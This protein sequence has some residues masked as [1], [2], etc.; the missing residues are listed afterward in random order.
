MVRDMQEVLL[1]GGNPKTPRSAE[2]GV[3]ASAGN[4][5]NDDDDDDDYNDGQHRAALEGRFLLDGMPVRLPVP[6]NASLPARVEALRM[7]L[8]EKLGTVAFLKVYRRLESLSIDD[9]EAQVSREFLQILGQ[10]KLG[11]LAL[12]HQLIICEENMM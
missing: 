9:D 3:S 6:D 2:K 12:V 7:Y 10:D 5:A 1:D 11:F 4:S 8:E